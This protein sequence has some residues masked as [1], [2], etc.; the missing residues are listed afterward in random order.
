MKRKILIVTTSYPKWEGDHNG[1]F[2]H[3]FLIHILDEFEVYV[4]APDTKGA[5]KIEVIDNINIIRFSQFPFIPV[6][7]AYGDDILAKI[8]KNRFLFFA[9]P[10]FIFNMFINV[11]KV[12]KKYRIDIIHAFWLIPQ[13][14]MAIFIKKLFFHKT[15]II[16]SLLGADINSFNGFWGRQMKKFALKHIDILISQSLPMAELAKKLGY[17]KDIHYLPLSIDTDF[18][19][20]KTNNTYGIYNAKEPVLLYVATLTERKGIS[21]LIEA[22]PKIKAIFP[23]FKLNIIGDGNQKDELILL[24]KKLDVYNNISFLGFKNPSELPK[25]FSEC[26]IFILPS[27]SEGFP[28]VVLS[29]L[30]CGAITVVTNLNVFLELKNE[31]PNLLHIVEKQNANAISDKVIYILNN[32]ESFKKFSLENRR[33]VVENFDIKVIANKYKKLLTQYIE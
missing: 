9:I 4:I 22:L 28:L 23:S 31:N 5:K 11:L 7:L 15:T 16:C 26:D 6:E 25:Y 17:N 32:F 10:F 2:I 3:N 1:Y 18:Y 14:F 29:A 12:Q 30:S 24:S 33:F 19:S 13:G 20:P 8:K 21:Y 27:L